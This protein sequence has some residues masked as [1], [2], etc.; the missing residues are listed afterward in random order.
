MTD[1]T[2]D[3]IADDIQSDYESETEAIDSLKWKQMLQE[4][5][6][7]IQ[8][9]IDTSNTSKMKASRIVARIHNGV[10]E[11]GEARVIIYLGG[12]QDENWDGD[13]LLPQ[14]ENAIKIFE[15]THPG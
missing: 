15:R 13:K 2:N 10:N 8:H 1:D 4:T 11:E 5:E 12:N 9:L 3:E 6:K 14:V 7:R